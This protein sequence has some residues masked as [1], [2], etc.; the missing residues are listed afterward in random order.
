MIANIL[1]LLMALLYLTGLLLV[2]LS[3][4]SDDAKVHM[5]NNLGCAQSILLANPCDLSTFHATYLELRI[6]LATPTEY[7]PNTFRFTTSTCPLR[8][9]LNRRSRPD[10]GASGT[11]FSLAHTC[12]LEIICVASHQVNGDI[13]AIPNIDDMPLLGMASQLRP[14]KQRELMGVELDNLRYAFAY[15]W[16]WKKAFLKYLNTYLILPIRADYLSIGFLDVWLPR[17][18]IANVTTWGL[19]VA[20]CAVRTLWTWS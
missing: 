9:V 15:L 17:W 6:V 4:L 20:A 18:S 1:I 14:D 8:G 16:I 5:L 10:T 13:E 19:F 2:E 12:G 11:R 3:H 7:T